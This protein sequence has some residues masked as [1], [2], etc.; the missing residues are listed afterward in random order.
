MGQLPIKCIACH[1]CLPLPISFIKYSKILIRYPI[2]NSNSYPPHDFFINLVYSI[3][4]LLR[5]LHDALQL[6][7]R[8]SRQNDS[9]I[10]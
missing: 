2:S 10:K 6:Q 4:E 5:K 1:N 9:R 3:Y 8:Q 7:K